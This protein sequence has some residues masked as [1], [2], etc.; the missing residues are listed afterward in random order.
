MRKETGEAIII[1]G[2]LIFFLILVWFVFMILVTLE[3][4]NSNSPLS[5]SVHI[6]HD[7]DGGCMYI[8]A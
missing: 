2:E 4:N 6:C 1:F 7:V 3:S 5:C 8:G